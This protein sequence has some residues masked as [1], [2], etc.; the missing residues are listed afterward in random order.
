MLFIQ[1]G[2]ANHPSPSLFIFVYAEAIMHKASFC[3][4]DVEGLQ[5]PKV[6]TGGVIYIRFH[7]TS[8]RYAGDYTEAM[9]GSWAEWIRENRKSADGVY[10]YFNND[11]LGHAVKNA[12]E[13]RE[14]LG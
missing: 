7:G 10:A 5:T 2:M 3:V 1:G 11:V 9:L 14:R 6:I 12:I 13:L 8:G 4:H